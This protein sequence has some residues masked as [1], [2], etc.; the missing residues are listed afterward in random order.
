VDGIVSILDNQAVLATSSGPTPPASPSW[1]IDQAPAEMDTVDYHVG[2]DPLA[3]GMAAGKML[4]SLVGDKP[5]KVVDL[6]GALSADNGIRR[7]KGFKDAIAAYPNITIECPRSRPSGG[8]S[9]RWPAWR[10]GS[11][12]TR[13]SARSTRPP[14]A[15]CR[16]SGPHYRKLIAT[17]RSARKVT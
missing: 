12:P 9:R 16:P 3:D 2:G 17:R 14:T 8:P 7:D 1:T 5:C 4:A 6:Q 13:T 10:T 15:C 11:R